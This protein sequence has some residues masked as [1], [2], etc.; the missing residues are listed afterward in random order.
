VVA[1]A[2]CRLPTFAAAVATFC[3]LAQLTSLAHFLLVLHAVCPEH[4][5]VVHAERMS[6]AGR[7]SSA[8]LADADGGV[9]TVRGRDDPGPGRDHDHGSILSDRREKATLQRLE[10]VRYAPQLLVEELELFFLEPLLA[11]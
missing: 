9:Q 2:S 8:A 7:P 10:V 5:E 11:H 1:R 6:G 3:L 4:G